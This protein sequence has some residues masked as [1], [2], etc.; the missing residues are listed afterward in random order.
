[1]YK[2]FDREGYMPLHDNLDQ[3]IADISRIGATPL[4]Q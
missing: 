1:M 2:L 4:H 3:V